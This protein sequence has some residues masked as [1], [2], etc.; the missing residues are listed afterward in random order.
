MI[1]KRIFNYSGIICLALACNACIP[2]LVRKT[3]NKATPASYKGS[4][5]SA[6][7]VKEKK[8]RQFFTD[9]NLVSL[10]DTALLKSQELNIVQQ[11]IIIAQNEARARKAAYLPF[12][13]VGA[14]AGIDKM[15]KYTRLGAVDEALDIKSG[16]RIPSPLPDFLLAA[17]ASWEVDIWKKLRN[18]RRAAL[19]RYLGSIEG[20]NFMVTLLV[21][22]I[23]NS[24]YELMALD[25]QLDILKQNIAIQ[26]N[27]LNIVIIQKQAAKVTE[28]AVKKFEAEVA[29]NQSRQYDIMQQIKVTENRINFLVG[30]FPQP[31]ARNSQTFMNLIPDSVK[32]GIPSQLLANRPDIRQAELE[33]A[34]AKLDV[35]SARANYYPSLMITGG[36]GFNAF[37]PSLLVTS[38]QSMFYNLAGS[39]FAPVI[40][41]NAITAYYYSSNARQT[42]S[43]WNYQRKILNGYMEVSNQLSNI[44]NLEQSF[45]YR[46]K[47]VDALIQ[48]I[49]ISINLF[50]SARANYLE[51]LMT[52]RD[53]IDARIDLIETKKRQMNAMVN[54]YQALG[55]GWEQ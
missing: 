53:V 1:R 44:T 31:I 55:G 45:N 48:S 15:G 20:R 52:Q 18:S 38:P 50:N 26:Q 39:F 25:N 36:V 22:E 28:L 21:A 54:L 24:Y 34:A 47:Q 16:Q 40:N 37:N 9:S 7:T 4:L 6:N 30:R 41:R 35:K 23:A 14:G 32:A 12:V 49:D 29:K 13:N 27:A 33:L 3:E 43:V 46:S 42:Q 2:S 10:I 51:I 8:W 11:E 5:D 19:K 17:N